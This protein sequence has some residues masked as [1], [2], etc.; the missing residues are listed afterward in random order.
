V[1]TTVSVFSNTQ[2]PP[3]QVAWLLNQFDA[4]QAA[5]GQSWVI[6]VGPSITD[7]VVVADG[8]DD[9]ASMPREFLDAAPEWLGGPPQY[10]LA[11][12]IGDSPAC[13]DLAW[14]IAEEFA[15][16]WPAVWSNHDSTEPAAPLGTWWAR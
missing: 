6:D 14:R 7:V 1:P 15:R 4:L 2:V 8:T 5:S 3:E 11:L 10:R 12:T 13:R 16:L 9:L